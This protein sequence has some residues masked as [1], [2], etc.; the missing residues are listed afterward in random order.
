MRKLFEWIGQSLKETTR[1]HITAPK[2]R[3]NWHSG[4]VCRMLRNP[5]YKEQAAFGKTNQ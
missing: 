5:A 2:G 4:T 1:R 3:R